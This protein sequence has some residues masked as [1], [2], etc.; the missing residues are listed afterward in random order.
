M[1]CPQC[2]SEQLR[3]S[4]YET[5]DKQTGYHEIGRQYLCLRCGAVSTE[6]EMEEMEK[7]NGT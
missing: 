1:T 2:G 5:V 3:C 6:A 7:A 4:T